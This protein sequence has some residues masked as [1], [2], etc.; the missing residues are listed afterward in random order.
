LL[1][2][3][4]YVNTRWASPPDAAPGGGRGPMELAGA[5]LRTAARLIGL[6]RSRLVR[7]RYANVLGGAVLLRRLAGPRLP[8]GLDG[9]LPAVERLYGG[10][11]ARQIFQTL[12][13]GARARVGGTLYGL[14][15]QRVAVPRSL[16]AATVGHADYP[17]AIWRPASPANYTR[18]NRPA[19][20][21]ILR[22][23]IHT[24]E[25]PYWSAIH[26]FQNPAARA[27]AHYVVRSSDGQVTQMIA[28]KDVAW[29]A[30]N[31]YYNA[32][33]IGIEHEAIVSN[34]SWYTN[35]MYRGS[36]RLVAYLVL[37]YAIP[38]DR[39]HIIGH[40]DVP[41]PNNP[42]LKG[43]A[44]HHTD[45]GPCWDWTKYLALV[46]EYAGRTDEA[47]VDNRGSRFAAPGWRAASG[48]SDLYGK[49]F[50]LARPSA[51]GVPATFRVRVPIPGT[52]AIYGWWPAYPNR[53]SSVPV[54]VATAAG[55]QRVLADERSSARAW[56]LLGT[57]DL[58]PGLRTVRFSRRTSTPG[59]ILADAIKVE[60]VRPIATASLGASGEGWALT[61]RQLSRTADGGSTWRSI[62]PPG[63]AARS[64]RAVDFA[65]ALHGRALALQPGSARL[66]LL[67]TEDGG[68]T[69]IRSS[70]SGPADLDA[71]GPMTLDFPDPVNGFVSVRRQARGV[72]AGLLLRTADGG[73]TWKSS[74]L[75]APGAIAFTSDT[76]GWLSSPETD[77][78][79]ATLNAGRSW[80]AVTV[81]RRSA[82]RGSIA[83]PG[84]PSFVDPSTAV[85]PV[86]LAGRRSAVEFATSVDGGRTWSVAVAIPTQH[87][88]ARAKALPA[89]VVDAGTWLAA[90]DG[91]RRIVVVGDGGR[92]LPVTPHSPPFGGTKPPVARLHFATASEGWAQV[93]SLCPLF[94]A[95]RCSGT[96]AL[97]STSDAGVTWRR[98]SPP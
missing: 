87:P 30:G 36:A 51:G 18:A 81:P 90:L 77:R 33:A 84:L 26:W 58:Q 82:Y 28:E 85:L 63:T 69:W 16:S 2:A 9:W 31:G 43:G 72:G 29:H 89:D 38:I 37:K 66:A 92:L 12:A 40:A 52:Y 55:T 79:Y 34:C 8:A 25:G 67:T 32:T 48:R 54:D 76:D 68:S 61:A 70:L 97:Y 95:P 21:P 19:S 15:P 49:S 44:G 91:G 47:I 96:Q 83:V 46:R 50:A 57:F 23:V 41:D 1:A 75:P 7:D 78:L 88:L 4:G 27:S 20:S 5:R 71:A 24:T 13:R 6:S 14:A 22:I 73:A 59:W 17:G 39:A 10:D 98:L 60:P 65:D 35:A 74:P 80:R 56:V 45:P 3:I 94:H 62:E 64:I 11:A 42:R 93:D 86:T 53:N